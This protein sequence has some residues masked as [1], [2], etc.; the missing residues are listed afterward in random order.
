M[1]NIKSDGYGF[2]A[3]V[4]LCGAAITIII[5]R[6]GVEKMTLDIVW[7][8]ARGGSLSKSFRY[9][10]PG[11]QVQNSIGWILICSMNTFIFQKWPQFRESSKRVIAVIAF[12]SPT[13]VYLWRE[14]T[15]MQ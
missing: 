4:M 9:G 11:A 5:R 8:L 15:T 6:H 14:I 1:M 12:K 7:S 2:Y 10:P 13:F 3:G